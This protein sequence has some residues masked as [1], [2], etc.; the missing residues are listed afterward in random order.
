MNLRDKL[1]AISS[2][3]KVQPAAPIEARVPECLHVMHLHPPEEFPGAEEVTREALMLMQGDEL[4][5]PFD[6]CRVLYL[7]TETTGFQGAGTVAFMIGV[8]FLTP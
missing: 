7:D 6:P 4:P 3:P 8:G 5:E 2:R 1:N